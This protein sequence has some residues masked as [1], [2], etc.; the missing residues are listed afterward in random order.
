MK[1]LG[2]PDQ[3]IAI[4]RG[5]STWKNDKIGM[6]IVSPFF[7]SVWKAMDKN[8]MLKIRKALMR[9]LAM[10]NQSKEQTLTFSEVSSIS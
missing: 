8:N 10:Q 6:N 5:H 1:R 7:Q 3:F 2:L 9:I 4:L